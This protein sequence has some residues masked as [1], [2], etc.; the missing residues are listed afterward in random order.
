MTID[1]EE[2]TENVENKGERAGYSATTARGWCCASIRK[3]TNPRANSA[4]T[5]SVLIR[6]SP[7]HADA[8]AKANGRDIC[9]VQT[10]SD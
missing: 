10:T 1:E 5:V 9:C 8:D 6:S 7:P 3:T 4:H 2:E